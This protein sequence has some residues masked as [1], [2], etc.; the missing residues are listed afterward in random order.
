MHILGIILF[1]MS[2]SF[3]MSVLAGYGKELKFLPNNCLKSNSFL[4]DTNVILLLY[5]AKKEKF[6]EHFG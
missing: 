5:C 2:F 3:L 4:T 6:F 1:N